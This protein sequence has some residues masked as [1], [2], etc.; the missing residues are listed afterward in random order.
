[1]MADGEDGGVEDVDKGRLPSLGFVLS[2]FFVCLRF[3]C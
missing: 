2:Y 3:Y 1:M